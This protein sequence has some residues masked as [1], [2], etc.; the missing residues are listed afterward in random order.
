M[1]VDGFLLSKNFAIIFM[2]LVIMSDLSCVK[3]SYVPSKCV[4]AVRL[5]GDHVETC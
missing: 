3:P 1:S 2:E 4:D 5:L